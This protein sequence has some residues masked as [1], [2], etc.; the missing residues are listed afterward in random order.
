MKLSTGDIEINFTYKDENDNT[1]TEN[2]I[3]MSYTDDYHIPLSL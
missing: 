3:T 1:Q 2:Y